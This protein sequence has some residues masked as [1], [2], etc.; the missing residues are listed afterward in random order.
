VGEDADYNDI[1]TAAIT[2]TNNA[3]YTQPCI[4]YFQL[5]DGGY[6]RDIAII[7]AGGVHT[8]EHVFAGVDIY[9]ANEVFAFDNS[10]PAVQIGSTVLP[11][12]KRNKFAQGFYYNVYTS[13]NPLIAPEGWHV[14]S[15][16]EYDTLANE[17]G[18]L[19]VAAGAMK[20]IRN[21]STIYLAWPSTN[22]A[23]NSSKMNIIRGSITSTGTLGLS[24]TN[25][26]TNDTRIKRCTTSENLSQV[27]NTPST[28]G[29]QIRLVKNEPDD[30]NIGDILTDIDGNEYET[31]KIGNQVWTTCS[32]YTTRLRDGSAIQKINN[33]TL[34]AAATDMA[35]CI[36][37][38]S[39]S[40][41][42]FN[43]LQ[44]YEKYKKGS[45]IDKFLIDYANQYKESNFLGAASYRYIY[46]ECDLGVNRT[47]Q[48]AEA[49]DYLVN[50]LGYV[51]TIVPW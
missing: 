44:L 15:L 42:F 18:G 6:H 16:E 34:W 7:E 37:S 36:A 45:Q 33:G 12:T 24:Y 14:P 4:V 47:A 25:L 26:L 48:S 40:A 5:N 2:A 1:I 39:Q 27:S 43:L 32:L 21:L 31:I 20:S 50:E 22:I 41:S 9:V 10:N 29:G 49:V 8:F 30:W 28:I 38:S 23:T 51:I 35:Y 13:V 19:S 11:A 46:I 17:L 3:I